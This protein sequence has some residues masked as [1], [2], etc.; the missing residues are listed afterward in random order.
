MKTVNTTI[1][2]IVCRSPQSTDCVP[3]AEHSAHSHHC[4]RSTHNIR[5]ARPVRNSDCLIGDHWSVKQIKHWL[6]N[7]NVMIQWDTDQLTLLRL[8]LWSSNYH[9]GNDLVSCWLWLVRHSWQLFATIQHYPDLDHCLMRY[10][11]S[12]STQFSEFTIILS[13]IYLS[14]ILAII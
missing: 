12:H 7:D 4:H 11:W 6:P 13:S 5:L 10:L 3:N 8:S 2:R 9:I 1:V 14:I